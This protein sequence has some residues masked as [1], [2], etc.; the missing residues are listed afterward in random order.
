MPLAAKTLTAPILTSCPV[1]PSDDQTWQM[2][3]KLPASMVVK[4]S[5]LKYKPI[6]MLIGLTNCRH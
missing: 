5:V 6:S 4:V 1:K 3:K 2:G